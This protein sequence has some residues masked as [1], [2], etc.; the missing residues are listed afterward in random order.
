MV[1]LLF[2]VQT[3]GIALINN[4]EQTQK[5]G[6]SANQRKAA[7]PGIGHMSWNAFLAEPI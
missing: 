3:H 7:A 1:D 2:I 5:T 6:F 4:G